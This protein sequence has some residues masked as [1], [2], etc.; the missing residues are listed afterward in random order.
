MLANN[1]DIVRNLKTAKEAWVHL[2]TIYE[3]NEGIQRCN[4]AILQHE[5]DNFVIL[6][7]ESPTDVFRR[8]TKLTMTMRENGKKDMD[9]EW[10]KSKLL[11]TLVP[12]NE[13]IVMNL[14]ARADYTTMCC[15]D[16]S[17][18]NLSPMTP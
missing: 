14:H 15:N 4:V 13:N 2:Q 16:T 9:D 10:V 17:W 3:G 1:E 18:H 11:K 7:D 6:E 8:L 5:V 12:H